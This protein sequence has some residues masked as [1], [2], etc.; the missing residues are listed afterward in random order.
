MSTHPRILIC[1]SRDWTDAGMIREFIL[2]L[3]TDS[4]IIHGDC[5]GADRIAGK[6]ALE[7]GMPVAAMP[8]PW[9]AFD[10]SAGPIR[11]GWLIEYLTPTEAHGFHDWIDSSRGTKD[12]RARCDRRGIPFRV[13]S[14]EMVALTEAK[15]D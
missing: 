12:M 13:H 15:N 8:A 11:N 6:E 3:P 9:Q 5:R 1:G 10:N 7:R 14:H 4:L 2:T